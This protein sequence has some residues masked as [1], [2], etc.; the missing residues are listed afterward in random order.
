[1]GMAPEMLT[2][3]PELPGLDVCQEAVASLEEE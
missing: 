3:A 2:L 1:M